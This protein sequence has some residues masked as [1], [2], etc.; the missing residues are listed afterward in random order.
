M[1]I[2]LFFWLLGGYGFAEWHAIPRDVLAF[3]L[4][5]EA[6][7]KLMEHWMRYVMGFL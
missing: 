1:L 5:S 3:F 6:I 2:N 4:T 7:T